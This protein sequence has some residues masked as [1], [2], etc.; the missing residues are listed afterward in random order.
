MSLSTEYKFDRIP[1]LFT[2][3]VNVGIDEGKITPRF[4]LAATSANITKDTACSAARNRRDKHPT[5]K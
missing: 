5:H 3:A 2:A 4:I 1:E